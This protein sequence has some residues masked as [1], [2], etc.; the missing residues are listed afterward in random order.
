MATVARTLPQVEYLGVSRAPVIPTGAY[1]TP[2]ESFFDSSTKRKMGESGAYNEME[3]GVLKTKKRR[4]K[5]KDLRKEKVVRIG[6]ETRVNPMRHITAY[7]GTGTSGTRH[8][9]HETANYTGRAAVGVAAGDGTTA[10]AID[11]PSGGLLSAPSDGGNQTAMPAT[12]VE[13]TGEGRH[14]EADALNVDDSFVQRLTKSGELKKVDV[15][16]LNYEILAG[17]VKGLK[18]LNNSRSNERLIHD[19]S[20]IKSTL[21]GGQRSDHTL[22]MLDT[23]A[24]MSEDPFGK[25]KY[26]AKPSQEIQHQMHRGVVNINHEGANMF[27]RG[28]N[29]RRNKHIRRKEADL[30]TEVPTLTPN[31]PDMINLDGNGMDIDDENKQWWYV[32]AEDRRF[33][34]SRRDELADKVAYAQR[35]YYT[36][37]DTT[38]GSDGVNV[39]V[40]DRPWLTRQGQSG[41]GHQGALQPGNRTHGGEGGARINEGRAQWGSGTSRISHGV[42][43]MQ[44]GVAPMAGFT[45]HVTT[46]GVRTLGGGGVARAGQSVVRNAGNRNAIGGQNDSGANQN[47]AGSSC[48]M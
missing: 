4:G 31:N 28:S 22:S 38:D 14:V 34:Y 27:T 48:A 39:L 26:N 40:T 18:N 19:A 23:A 9:A 10:M 37:A 45:T 46:N 7:A 44:G 43:T 41:R 20:F 42:E 17:S 3:K 47:A 16:S 1:K 29:Q 35:S 24:V 5:D 2:A 11:T 36:G 12:A 8:G 13:G 33:H 32:P 25:H 21:E 6:T 30:G 15:A